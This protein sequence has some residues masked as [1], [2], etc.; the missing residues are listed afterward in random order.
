MALPQRRQRVPIGVERRRAGV[1]QRGQ[2][3]GAQLVDGD[4]FARHELV[5]GRL[6][7]DLSKRIA[8]LFLC[9]VPAADLLPPARLR[10]EPCVDRKLV[11]DNGFPGFAVGDFDLLICGEVA[12]YSFG[13]GLLV[14]RLGHSLQRRKV[15]DCVEAGLSA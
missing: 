2:P 5:G 15:V 13:S 6:L 9:R 7:A 3:V 11:P 14:C 8:G 12:V 4:R 10:I 1:V